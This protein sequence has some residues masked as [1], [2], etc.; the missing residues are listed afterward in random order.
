MNNDID[1]ID[2]TEV[3]VLG[4][5]NDDENQVESNYINTTSNNINNKKNDNDK[6]I[7]RMKI[8]IVLLSVLIIVVA[9]IG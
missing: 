5:N 8:G 6:N 1:D 3:E 9:S 2:E 4:Y 7:R